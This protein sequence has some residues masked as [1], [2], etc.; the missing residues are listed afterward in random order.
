MIFLNGS[1]ASLAEIVDSLLDD[2]VG[3]I[4][5]ITEIPISAGAPAFFRFHST[6]SNTKAFTRQ[7][8]SELNG[9][10]SIDRDVA[11]AKAI[12]EGVERYCSA[13]YDQSELILSTYNDAVIKCTRPED[14]ALYDVIQYREPGFPYVPFDRD[15][16]VRWA[17][18]ID[19]LNNEV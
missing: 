3:V 17:P 12:G 4:N 1:H 13:I 19:P 9:G 15:T 5:N 2:E 11:L 6:A 14:F 7:A 8:N 18:A 10:A 16:P